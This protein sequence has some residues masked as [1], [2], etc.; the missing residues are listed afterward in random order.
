MATNS[1]LLTYQREILGHVKTLRN[2]VKK[3]YKVYEEQIEKD[4][5]KC[6]PTQRACDCASIK[7]GFLVM[8]EILEVIN[9]SVEDSFLYLAKKMESG[10][11]NL[12]VIQMLPFHK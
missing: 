1:K 10:T 7:K 11:Y 2:L 12:I 9:T 6:R 8:D 3:V 4:Y 5:S